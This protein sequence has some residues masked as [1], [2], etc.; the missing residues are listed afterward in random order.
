MNSKKHYL[1]PALA[2]AL[3]VVGAVPARAGFILTTD[4]INPTPGHNDFNAHLPSYFSQG[5]G[6]VLDISGPGTIEFFFDG[7]EAGYTNTFRSTIAGIDYTR[8]ANDLSWNG[9][10]HSLGS[11]LF[12][13]GSLM[14]DWIF[15]SVQGVD[16]KGIATNA[17]GIFLAGSA[18]LSGVDVGNI[19]HLGFD[20]QSE[21]AD[22]NHDDFMITAVF[23]PADRPSTVPAPATLWLLGPG[24]LGFAAR[25][26]RESS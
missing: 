9:Q 14:G 13:P 22:D 6:Q 10:S 17:F 20:D 5:A 7:K 12:G 26:K 19:I 4:I 16:N 2:A 11:G 1:L 8:S 24:F 21:I 23:T 3:L 25:R 18:P 15:D